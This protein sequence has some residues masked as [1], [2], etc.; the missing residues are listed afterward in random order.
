MDEALDGF[1]KNVLHQTH[2]YNRLMDRQSDGC[3]TNNNNSSNMH[4][5]VK[6][7]GEN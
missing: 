1:A 3:I 2:N 4:S 7:S 5:T 6:V